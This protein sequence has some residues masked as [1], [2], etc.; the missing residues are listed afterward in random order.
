MTFDSTGNF[1]YFFDGNTRKIVNVNSRE[2]FRTDQ[3]TTNYTFLAGSRK[4]D[5]EDITVGVSQS[6]K[7]AVFDDYSML[8]SYSFQD[9]NVVTFCEGK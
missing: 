8:E 7:I 9:A 4:S 6:G 5:F 2:L 3:F 1:L